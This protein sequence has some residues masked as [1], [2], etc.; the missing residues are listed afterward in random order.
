[1][2]GTVLASVGVALIAVVVGFNLLLATR[3]SSDADAVLRARAS[4]ELA[5]LRIVNGRIKVAEAPDEGALDSQVWV[6][7]GSREVEG[8]RTAAVLNRAAAALARRG[9]GH[10]ELSSPRSRLYAAPVE[11][12]RRR[13]GTVVAA[14]SL[15]PYRRTQR[16]ALV[17]SGVLALVLFLVSAVLARWL[18]GAALRPVAQMTE[19]ASEWSE[20]DL[21]RRFGLG[22]PHDEL[23]KLAATLDRLLDRITASLRREQRF[24]AEISHELRT[25]LAR[26]SAE[27]ELALGQERTTAEYRAALESVRANAEQLA[28]AVETL[29]AAARAESSPRGTADAGAAIA[30]AADAC[31]GLAEERGIE[32]SVVAPPRPVRV[33]TDAQVLERVLVPLIENA[34]HYGRGRVEVRASADS[35]GISITVDDDGP[36]VAVGERE[37]IFEPGERGSAAEAVGRER[38][39]GLGL[40]LARRL[41]QAAGGD[42]AAEPGAGGGRFR[43]TLPGG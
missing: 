13:L 36:G 17:A 12:A 9:G 30:R 2:L 26:I 3:L 4:A 43:V 35:T 42:I 41:A 19:Q 25:P 5:T 22:A 15:D 38:G 10:V 11:E 28:G 6:F 1:L 16:I 34:C 21:D 14:I 7:A 40:A 37:R 8:P 23:T 27:A 24:S 18:L 29:V 39:A 32:L 20:R 33:D 31:A